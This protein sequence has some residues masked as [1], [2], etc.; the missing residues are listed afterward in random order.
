MPVARTMKYKSPIGPLLATEQVA[1]KTHSKSSASRILAQKGRPNQ[2]RTKANSTLHTDEQVNDIVDKTINDWSVAPSTRK[3][4]DGV[5]KAA[6]QWLSQW[7]ASGG[8]RGNDGNGNTVIMNDAFDSPHGYTPEAMMKFLAYKC[9]PDPV[10]GAHR[11][12]QSTA[13]QIHASLKAYF[14][15]YAFSSC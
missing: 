9:E 4:Y 5:L 10:T 6:R 2:Q 7:I 11:C 12:G 14:T 1:I 13:D 15:T 8:G 3:K